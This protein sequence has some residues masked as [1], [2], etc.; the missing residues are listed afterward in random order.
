M[1]SYKISQTELD[2]GMFEALRLKV[3][4]YG[5][6]P[7]FTLYSNADDYESAKQDIID[8]GK[9]II[10]VHGQGSWKSRGEKNIN[11][12][13]IDRG[14]PAPA[15]SGIGKSFEYDLNDTKDKYNKTKI[16]DTK[17]DC[18]YKITYMCQTSKYCNIIEDIIR[19]TFGARKLIN[20][21]NDDEE[22]TGEVWIYYSSE[23]DTSG[24]D[25]IERGVNYITKNVDL[26]GA[27]F[28]EEIT[29]F[30]ADEFK[31]EQKLI[32]REDKDLSITL[33]TNTVVKV[34]KVD[35]EI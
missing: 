10:E 33:K 13:V 15:K 2:N 17:W 32:L 24:T 16:A 21:I 25:F 27:E 30:N 4:S 3:V 22:I 29:P 7:D 5:Y 11:N 23:F 20:C 12:I 8:A 14:T 1:A 31:L 28:I 35:G 6:L 19:S 34:D 18:P 26:Q 9:E